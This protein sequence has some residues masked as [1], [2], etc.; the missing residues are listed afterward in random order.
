MCR[1]IFFSVLP[2]ASATRTHIHTHTQKKVLKKLSFV[3]SLENRLRY[4]TSTGRLFFIVYGTYFMDTLF[5]LLENGEKT[6][7]TL[8]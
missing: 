5:E 6:D 1:T 4:H 8:T 2:I 7:I 3:E